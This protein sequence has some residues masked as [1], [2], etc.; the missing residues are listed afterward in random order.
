MNVIEKWLLED[1]R[2]EIS[3]CANP[4][5]GGIAIFAKEGNRTISEVSEDTLEEAIGAFMKKNMIGGA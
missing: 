4:A 3:I 1:S 2:R 5:D